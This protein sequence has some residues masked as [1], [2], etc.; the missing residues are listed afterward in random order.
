MKFRDLSI[1]TKLILLAMASASLALILSCI[2][3]ALNN[4]QMMRN[5]T[6]QSL[7]TQARMLAFNSTAVLSFRDAA[8]AEQLLKSMRSQPLIEFACLYDS[9][10]KVLATYSKDEASDSIPPLPGENGYQF[11]GRGTL[12]MF[13]K[14]QD[15]NEFV[16]TLYL[17][18][19]I[20]FLR[21]QAYDYV[22]I[23]ALMMLCSLLASGVLASNLQ[24]AVSK[25]ILA[26]TRT[27]VEIT[28]AGDYSI[29]VQHESR[30]E[31]GTLYAAFNEMLERVETSEKQLLTAQNALEEKVL[32]RTAQLS[33]EIA[34]KERAQAELQR[35]KDAAESATRS[36]SEFLANMSHEIRTPITAIL[37]FVEVLLEEQKGDWGK[38]ELATIQ[39]NGEHLLAVINDILDISKIEARRM[40]VERVPCSP[41][42]VVADVNSLMHPRA[43]AKGLTLRVDFQSPIPETIHTDPTRVRQILINLIGNA[44]KFTEAGEITL[45][46]SFLPGDRPMMCF[47][48]IDTGIGMTEQETAKLFQEFSQAETST[49]RRF[50][51]TGLGLAISKRLAHM[52]GGDVTLVQSRPGEGTHFRV[53]IAA[54]PVEGIGMLEKPN[55]LAFRESAKQAGVGQK[56]APAIALCGKILLAEDGPDNQR[57]ISHILT[58]AGAEVVVVDN[59]KK[60]VEAAKAAANAGQAFDLILMDMQM[61]V[62]DGYEATATLRAE[63]YAGS[64]V[65]LTAHAMASDRQKCINAGCND[66]ATKPIDR[67]QFF[68]TLAK[69]VGEGKQA[70][71]K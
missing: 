46:A 1:R 27:A 59:G 12:E 70:M 19:N 34:E 28:S 37:G 45:G 7:S 38:D 9:A 29:R 13:W 18:E 36:K 11:T 6:V 66:Y 42:Q 25:P 61:P 48:V 71:R 21:Q 23:A 69:Y 22:K 50:G 17:S 56:P 47:D 2:G 14:V 43:S 62:M 54:G 35:A 5:S 58:R 41:V 10:G 40:S 3:L 20:T 64:I 52:L 33:K 16:G 67:K 44:I 39:R 63:G 31:L 4:I 53:T 15:G 65:A 30:D 60:A 26:L 8:A 55:L 32:E 49:A 24:R 57:L 68:A 51:G